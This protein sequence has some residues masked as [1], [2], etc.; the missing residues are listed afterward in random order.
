MNFAQDILLENNRAQLRPL[1]ADD[2]EAL[3]PVA[4]DPEL[5]QFT[6]TRGDDRIGLAAYI[7]AAVQGREQQQRYPFVIVDKQTNRV[8][9]SS[10][11]YNIYLDDAR[12][13]IG[14]TWV[15]TDF[16]RSGLNRAAKHLL[17]R[18][19]FDVLGCERVELETDTHN[20][21]SQAAMRRM[22]ATEEGTLRSHR[23]TQGGRRR[24][25]VIFSVLKPEWHQLRTTTFQDFEPHA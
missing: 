23:Y 25:T 10:S 15:G 22:G 20:L 18:H 4:F 13:S 3:Q 21:K 17:F 1:T 6:L 24:D 19:A 16:Q 7:A 9:G 5:W 2:F 12:L 11:Y 8:A 14:Y